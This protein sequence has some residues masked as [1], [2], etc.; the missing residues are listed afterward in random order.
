MF[1]DDS[2]RALQGAAG[3]VQPGDRGVIRVGGTD[4]ATWLQGLLTNDIAALRAGH[5]CYAAWLTPQGRMLSDMQV[6][7]TGNAVWLDVPGTLA[8]RLTAELD[9]MIFAEDVH[10]EDLVGRLTVVGVHGPAAPRVVSTAI[11]AAI[12][13]AEL[14]DWVRY[15]HAAIPFDG[16]EVRV[17]RVEPYGV[18]GY[19]IYLEPS[20]APALVSRLTGAGAVPVS[21]EA[22]ETARIEAGHPQ[23][24]VDM[25]EH[26]IP[27]EAGIEGEAISLT[28]G[29][30][31]GQ[32]V[33]VRVLHR[34]QGRVARKLAGM[35]FGGTTVPA[36]GAIV[37]VGGREVGRVTSAALSPRLGCA[38]ALGYLHRDVLQ[39]GTAIEALHGDTTLSGVVHA[40]PFR[41][42]AGSLL[43]GQP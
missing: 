21:A 39:P 37:R 22:A 34:G 24:L 28:K 2:Y 40:L 32:E 26:T 43:E 14:Q 4:R 12:P 9:R 7:E 17:A 30:Y 33:I 42:S 18:P 31:V 23:F 6:L 1:S 5:G 3:L 8:H 15:R 35:A 16:G 19:D 13:A 29:C 27:L 25:D 38:V 41:E 11:G 36:T 10:V 20:R